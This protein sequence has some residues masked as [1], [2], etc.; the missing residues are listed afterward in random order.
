LSKAK[1]FPSHDDD[2]EEDDYKRGEYEC[3]V[4]M[5]LFVDEK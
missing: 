5:K 2:D 4:N 3:V 1:L